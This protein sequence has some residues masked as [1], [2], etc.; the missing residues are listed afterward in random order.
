MLYEN[1]LKFCIEKGVTVRQLE[2]DLSLPRD[3][4]YKLGHLIKEPG[5]YHIAKIARYFNISIEKL[6]G[7]EKQEG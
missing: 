7:M 2:R 4:I 3:Y 5:V 1:I 6:I